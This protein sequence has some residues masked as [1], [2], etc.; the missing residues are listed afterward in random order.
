M[1]TTML[2]DTSDKGL[3]PTRTHNLE[4]V[5][6]KEIVAHLRKGGTT[7]G[8]SISFAVNHATGEVIEVFKK[9]H[10]NQKDVKPLIEAGFSEWF[11]SWAFATKNFL[12]ADGRQ[13]KLGRK[14]DLVK[15]E[16]ILVWAKA[17]GK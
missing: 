17:F 15:T 16:D 9:G 5:N 4:S 2:Y 10:V 1:P 3:V 14:L 7:A 8:F 6:P 12:L 13:V 11:F